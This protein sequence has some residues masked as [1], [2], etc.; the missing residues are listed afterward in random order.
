MESL[1]DAIASFNPMNH[2]NRILIVAG[3]A[4][5]LGLAL[6]VLKCVLAY[7]CKIISQIDRKKAIYTVR[8]HNLR[9]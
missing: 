3:V 5:V 8:L 1:A 7:L 4:L 9:K 2:F 6:L